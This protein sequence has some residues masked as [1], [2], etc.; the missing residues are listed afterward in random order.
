V[1]LSSRAASRAHRNVRK[2]IWARRSP[3]PAARAPGSPPMA[4]IARDAQAG[5]TAG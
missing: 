1:V 3:G 2:A 5:H 4:G